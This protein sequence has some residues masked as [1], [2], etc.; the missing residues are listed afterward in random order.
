MTPLLPC[1]LPIADVP[2]RKRAQKRVIAIALLAG[3][4]SFLHD[5]LSNRLSAAEPGQTISMSD[6]F[7]AE[8]SRVCLRSPYQRASLTLD[9]PNG[10]ELDE[11]SWAF[12]LDKAGEIER[13]IYRRSARL[14]VMLEHE[15]GGQSP[16]LPQKLKLTACAS[17]Q[18]GVVVRF[19]RGNRKYITLAEPKA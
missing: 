1:R 7:A 4:C 9:D 10:P 13:R 5:E 19:E 8:V 11:G 12:V 15:L 2:A 6:L 17:R 14:D 16:I 3:G 18:N